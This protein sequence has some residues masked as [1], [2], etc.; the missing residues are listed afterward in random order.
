MEHGYKTTWG[1]LDALQRVALEEGLDTVPHLPCILS[2][3]N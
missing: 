1:E 2:K 3:K